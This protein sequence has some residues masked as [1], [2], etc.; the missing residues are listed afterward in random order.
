MPTVN[1]ICLVLVV[2]LLDDCMGAAYENRLPG[3]SVQYEFTRA[4]CEQGAFGQSSVNWFGTLEA[5]TDLLV[6]RSGNGVQAA[7]GSLVGL[8]PL[9]S[10]GSAA[11]MIAWIDDEAQCDG[12]T[13]ELWLEHDFSSS[14]VNIPSGGLIFQVIFTINPTGPSSDGCDIPDFSL[15]LAKDGKFYLRYRVDGNSCQDF[16]SIL[17]AVTAS[18]FMHLVLSLDLSS[19]ILSCYQNGALVA[20]LFVIYPTDFVFIPPVMKQVRTFGSQWRSES[21][22]HMFSDKTAVSGSSMEWGASVASFVPWPGTI[23][24]MAMYGHTVSN[25]EVLQ[26]YQSGLP[27]SSPVASNAT[28]LYPEDGCYAGQQACPHTAALDLEELQLPA[29]YDADTEVNHP[30][31]LSSQGASYFLASIPDRGDLFDVA[32]NPITADS[33]PYNLSSNILRYRPLGNESS[34]P[35]EYTS[36]DYFVSDGIDLSNTATVSIVI[37]PQNDEPIA[38]DTVATAQAGVLSRICVEGYD[39]DTG[40]AAVSASV[41]SLPAHGPLLTA[42]GLSPLEVGDVISDLCFGYRYDGEIGAAD[43]LGLV[44]NDSFLF[45]VVDQSGYQSLPGTALIDVYSGISAGFYSPS[46][47]NGSKFSPKGHEC[48]PCNDTNTPALLY[49]HS[50]QGVEGL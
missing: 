48:S 42:D 49:R 44:A 13:M 39:I 1:G 11:E 28:V 23:H 2:A 21:R 29:P 19:G 16:V 33:L 4:Q 27:N 31:Y 43:A 3:A 41:K 30:N 18:S 46:D 10:V 5:A 40:D 26:N 12:L 25:G 32:G 24:L 47:N 8:E 36:F 6:C 17:P 35:T 15:L 50:G 22:L 38:L 34:A 45:S 9:L 7:S 14:S 20:S 37:E